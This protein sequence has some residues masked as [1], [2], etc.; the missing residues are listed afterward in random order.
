MIPESILRDIW[1]RS[2]WVHLIGAPGG[3][4]ILIKINKWHL[5]SIAGHSANYLLK[6]EHLATSLNQD[7]RRDVHLPSTQRLL[8]R[9]STRGT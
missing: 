8:M 3:A 1:Y 7:H 9:F 4:P 5:A 6:I 2:R